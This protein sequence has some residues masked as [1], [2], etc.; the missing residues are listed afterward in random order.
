MTVDPISG[1]LVQRSLQRWHRPELTLV[2][3][4][5]EWGV[6]NVVMVGVAVLGRVVPLAWTLLSHH[7]SSDFQEQQALLERV[8]PWWPAAPQQAVLGD[9]ECKSG[10]RM[11][12]T[13]RWGWDFG[14][15]Q[16]ADTRLQ[17][18]DG[19]WQRL[20]ALQVPKDRPLSLSGIRLTREQAFGPVHLIADGDRTKPEQRSVATSRP[21]TATTFAGGRQRSGIEGLFRDAQSGGFP[22]EATHLTEADRLHRWLLVMAIGSLGCF[23]GGRWLCKTG[24]RQVVDAA[25]RRTLPY[26]RLGC[27]WI[28]RAINSGQPGKIGFVVYTCM[29]QPKVTP[30]EEVK[31]LRYWLMC[32]CPT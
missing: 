6:W 24:Q 8:R 28:R 5:T 14:V 10:E 4:R 25:K 13:L 26:V 17:G 30:S 20:G 29:L 2:L 16:S 7:G 31:Q 32:S 18:P 9:G 19:G 21:A 22:R 12:Y 23:H 27:D 3:D 1:P 15:G 11:R